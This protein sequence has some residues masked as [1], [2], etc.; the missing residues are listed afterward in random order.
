[1]KN[2]SWNKPELVVL[3]RSRP[4]CVVLARFGPL[5]IFLKRCFAFDS[6]AYLLEAEPCHLEVADARGRVAGLKL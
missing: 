4:D 5:M 1:M 2:N 3:T 6:P